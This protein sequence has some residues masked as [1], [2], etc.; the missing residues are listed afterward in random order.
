[1]KFIDM[2]S[3]TK[4]EVCRTYAC[5]EGWYELGKNHKAIN[6]EYVTYL[7]G[8]NR[9]ALDGIPQRVLRGWAKHNP[10]VWGNSMFSA[11]LKRDRRFGSNA[12][13]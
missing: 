8:C 13:H 10:E 11:A 12:S 7:N 5:H 9:I 1:M 4:G 3:L 6:Q 2:L